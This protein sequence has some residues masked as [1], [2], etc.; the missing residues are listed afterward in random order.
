MKIGY[1]RCSQ[2]KRYR[3]GPTNKT[4]PPK[5]KPYSTSASELTASTPTTASPVE[6]K[7][8]PMRKLSLN[9]LATF[10]ESA[11]KPWILLP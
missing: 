10:D 3:P 6:I 9:I 11:N 5:P 7:P 1:A 8:D 4:S 2:A